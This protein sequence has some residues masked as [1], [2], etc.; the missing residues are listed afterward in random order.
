MN[1]LQIF[2]FILSIEMSILLEQSLYSVKEGML[3]CLMQSSLNQCTAVK[4]EPNNFQCCN[5]KGK[6][7]KE[8]SEPSIF[9]YCTPMINPIKQAQ[10][11]MNTEEGKMISKENLGYTLYSNE[12][13]LSVESNYTCLDG[14]LEFKAEA[15][16]YNEE[17]K[18]KFKSQ[19]HC[20]KHSFFTNDLSKETCYKSILSSV[21]NAGVSCGH[22]EIKVNYIDGKTDNYKTCFFFKDNTLETK[23][24]GFWVKE[25]IEEH[26]AGRAEE[27]RT[28]VSD[29][30]IIASNSKGQS[31]I[32][33][34]LND[35]IIEGKGGSDGSDGNDGTTAKFLYI[36]YLLL[37]ISLLI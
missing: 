10:D 7:Q 33:F 19:N 23:N 5:L 18:E 26:S 25:K 36:K 16:D 11:D 6:M 34:S 27:L 14:N 32:Y 29:Y 12:D 35:T 9:E 4:I 2:C 30:Q 15:K 17:E 8:G 31:F 37:L 1:K 28:K 24:M 21:G 22:Y 3:E 20:L 13:L